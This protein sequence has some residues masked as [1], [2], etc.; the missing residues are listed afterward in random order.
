MPES[1]APRVPSAPLA[2]GAGGAGA[3]ARRRWAPALFVAG[4]IA[5]AFNLRAAITSLPPLFPEL[6]AAL[7][8]SS[9]ALALLAATP[10][11]CF[12]LF[13]GVA[14][15]LSRRFGEERVLLAALALLAVGL[16]LRGAVPGL[17]L[18]P[19]TALAA[20]AIA[21]MNVLLPS[22]VKRRQPAQAGW[23]IGIYLLSLSAGTILGAL[24]AVPLFVFMGVLLE[25]S[26]IA[27][28]MLDVMGLMA[29]KI[30]GGMSIG[31]IV[32][33]ILMGAATGIV[34]ATVVTVSLL[35]L[36]TLLKRGYN[37]GLACGTICA[38]G[39]LGQIISPSL[40]LSL[41][42]DLVGVLGVALQH[43]RRDDRVEP[44]PLLPLPRVRDRGAAAQHDLAPGLTSRWGSARLPLAPRGG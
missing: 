2:E 23:L 41:L 37:K 22:L 26:R 34:G 35:S 31:I 5:L 33:G 12:A 36:P 42:A 11:V 14:A 30:P 16:L 9:A 20:A 6:S 19:G 3:P 4:I 44:G 27:E 1:A 8:L 15:P 29:G 28:E 10:V 17:L 13:S 18:I 39:T 38:S 21:L 40:I 25:K 32:I 24:V 43:D 7:H